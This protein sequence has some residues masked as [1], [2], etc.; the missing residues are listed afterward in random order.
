MFLLNTQTISIDSQAATCPL[1][2]LSI[3][4]PKVARNGTVQQPG[5]PASGEE[6]SRTGKSAD[7]SSRSHRRKNGYCPAA[8]AA[9]RDAQLLLSRC[10]MKANEY[11]RM[12]FLDITGLCALL[13]RP[14]RL[15][16]SA[17]IL[18]PSTLLYFH[19][20]LKKRKYRLLFSPKTW[21]KP[22]P[23]GP[24]QELI[25]AVVQMKQRNPLTAEDFHL[26]R[27]A[28]LS[29]APPIFDVHLGTAIDVHRRRPAG[30]E[31]SWFGVRGVKILTGA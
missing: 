1:V 14:S 6:P 12:Q 23:K 17:I 21:T 4:L 26:I 3:P 30:S 11:A 10:G 25:E 9:R 20:V 31:R 29:A 16:R 22:G 19:D 2:P 28:A 15:I 7:N 8:T 18:K 27:F 13:M 5:G 24:A